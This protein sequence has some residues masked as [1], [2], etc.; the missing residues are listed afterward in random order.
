[1]PSRESEERY[2]SVLFERLGWSKPA[3]QFGERPDIRFEREG[4]TYGMEVTECTPEELHRAR[5]IAKEL[6]GFS[7]FSTSHL[8]EEKPKRSRHEVVDSMFNE[9]DAVGAGQALSRWCERVCERV[10][11]KRNKLNE[12]DYERFDENWLLVWDGD[13][14][15]NDVPTLQTFPE[16]VR[17]S[18]ISAPTGMDEFDS[19]Y[20]ISDDYWFHV[21]DKK[22]GFFHTKA[23]E[24]NKLLGGDI[25]D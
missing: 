17:R 20:V 10:Q 4:L 13:G 11:R 18:P 6:P 8:D 3:I 1:M 9:P 25:A 5:V 7:I 24:V 22:I 19:I 14:L 21:L 16:Y 15:W 12:E 23:D 2:A